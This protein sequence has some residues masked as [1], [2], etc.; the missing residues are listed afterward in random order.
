[1]PTALCF[2]QLCFN[3]E[4][5]Q[6]KRIEGGLDVTVMDGLVLETAKATMKW[7]FVGLAKLNL[8]AKRLVRRCRYL[9]AIDF[10]L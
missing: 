1:M 8:V 10:R 2:R 7:D 4:L 6:K 3:S 9:Q 5:L